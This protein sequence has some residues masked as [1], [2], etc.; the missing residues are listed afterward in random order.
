MYV[1][2][3]ILEESR[4]MINNQYIISIISFSA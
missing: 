4:K 3:K 2:I 1:M